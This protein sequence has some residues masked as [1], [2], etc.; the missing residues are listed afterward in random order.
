VNK[1]DE[2]KRSMYRAVTA[3]LGDHRPRV[4][5]VHALSFTPGEC[6]EVDRGQY[7]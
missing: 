3:V 7:G 4:E 5:S 1:H 6:A 2:S